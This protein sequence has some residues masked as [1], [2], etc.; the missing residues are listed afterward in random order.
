M[1]LSITLSIAFALV[2]FAL[3]PDY[4]SLSRSVL[5]AVGCGIFAFVVLAGFRM[6]FRKIS[7]RQALGMSVGMLTATFIYLA[8]LTI[9]N[10]FPLAGP[11]LPHVKAGIFL[12]LL[13][14]GAV[15]GFDKTSLA[16]AASDS[17]FRQP[18]ALAPKILDTSVII[19]GRIADIAETGFLQGE[20]II[21]KFIIQELQ[22]IADS[23][24]PARKT[25]GRRGLDIINRMQNDIPSISVSIT[26]HDFEHR[27]DADIKLIELSKKLNGILVTNDYN[28]KKIADLEKITVLNINNLNHALRPVVEQG[29]TIRISLVKPGKE[30]HQAVG[31]LDDGTMVVTDNASRQIGKDV[32][33]SVRSMVQTPT[34]RIVFA[35]LKK[36]G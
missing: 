25:R 30:Q 1:R 20:L 22:Y 21:P 17:F 18:E 27:K 3:G 32:D 9:L 31:Y 10:S 7:L 5:T 2:A 35:K 29:Q 4:L 14:V 23:S 13:C 11:L 24:D 28:L 8:V 36:E 34:G 26:D 15:I 33:V 12:L 6:L 19:D 16:T